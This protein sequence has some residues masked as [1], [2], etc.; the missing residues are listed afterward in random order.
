VE[1][2]NAGKAD[3]VHSISR[4]IDAQLWESVDHDGL[5]NLLDSLNGKPLS[6]N[7]FDLVALFSFVF[8]IKL[9]LTVLF[10]FF[11]ADHRITFAV[12]FVLPE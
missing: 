7:R 9:C 4:K 10:S 8:R 6:S 2:N 12:E 11:V 1:V 5:L 3:S